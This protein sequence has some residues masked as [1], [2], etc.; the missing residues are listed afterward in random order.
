MRIHASHCLSSDLHV[1]H[2]A[3][4]HFPHREARV[5]LLRQSRPIPGMGD[6]VVP[7][8]L[9]AAIPEHCSEKHGN[10]RGAP[11]KALHSLDQTLS[12]RLELH[13]QS[14]SD[15]LVRSLQSDLVLLHRF[16][17]LVE[18]VLLADV[19]RSIFVLES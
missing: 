17:H 7:G 10:S 13:E 18:P 5:H 2:L 8:D 12:D 19:D 16:E 6:E 11:L 3:P 1:L 14:H 4:N 15:A 9:L